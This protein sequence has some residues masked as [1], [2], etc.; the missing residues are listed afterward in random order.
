MKMNRLIKAICAGFI[1][2]CTFG[3]M[4]FTN[5]GGETDVYANQIHNVPVTISSTDSTITR[6][7]EVHVGDSIKVHVT[8]NTNYDV[9]PS[10][11][12][13]AG[14]GLNSPNMTPNTVLRNGGTGVYAY[15]GSAQGS[16]ILYFKLINS[17]DM[18]T[19]GEITIQ[20]T[21]KDAQGQIVGTRPW[22]PGGGAGAGGSANASGSTGDGSS[23]T[24]SYE[25]KTSQEPT[26]D[27]DGEEIYVC[28]GCGDVLY[29]RGLTAMGVFEKESANK[30]KNAPSHGKVL[31]ESSNWNTLGTDTKEAM[32][33]RPDV[34]VSASFLSEGYKGK[35]LHVTIPAGYN[36]NSLYDK[37]GFC[38]LC[39]AGTILGYDQ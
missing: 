28:S 2:L 34:T 31:I 17:I 27:A 19:K 26:A 37:N 30:I 16:G 23:H 1:A 36:I 13:Y 3:V 20:L 21:V 12:T 33:A 38:G 4:F 8:N 24:H 9:I 18:T 39:H 29:R 22:V 11:D 35:R 7:V 10:S 6:D 5:A 25:W 32:L 14:T 15:N